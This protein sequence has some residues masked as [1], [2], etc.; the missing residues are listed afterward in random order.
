M[1]NDEQ[2]FFRKKKKRNLNLTHECKLDGKRKLKP[3]VIN[4]ETVVVYYP[5]RYRI[6]PS[7]VYNIMK[8]NFNASTE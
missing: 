6:P 3:V 7:T 8:D 5:V 1:N 2:N 4:L